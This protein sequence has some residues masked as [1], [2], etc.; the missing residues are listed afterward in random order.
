MKAVHWLGLREVSRTWIGRRPLCSRPGALESGR[1]LSW[2]SSSRSWVHRFGRAHPKSPPT[3]TTRGCW[4]FGTAEGTELPVRSAADWQV[5]R[6]HILANLQAVMGPA[7]RRR[8]S[9]SL[10]TLRFS[11]RSKNRPTSA[12]RSA[13]RVN[14]GDRVPAW[15]LVPKANGANGSQTKRPA[16]LA[17]HQTTAI[18]KDEPAGLGG[19]RTFTTPKSWWSEATWSSS[20]T[21]PTLG[22]TRSIPTPLATPAPR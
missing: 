6:A 15:L 10:L 5:R 2:V 22:S 19:S 21:T 13:M 12:R 8:T 4:W 20:P 11:K 17:L 9:R 16:I 3:P 1:G 7:A 14:R 18:G